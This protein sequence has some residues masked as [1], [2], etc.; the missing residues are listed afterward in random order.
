MG[1]RLPVRRLLATRQRRLESGSERS[2]DRSAIPP[3]LGEPSAATLGRC[4]RLHRGMIPPERLP[5]ARRVGHDEHGRGDLEGA[6]YGQRVQEDAEIRIIE[7]D[8]GDL[9]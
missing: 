9:T 8:G 7:R 4:H 5:T 6:Q 1:N 2:K 3:K